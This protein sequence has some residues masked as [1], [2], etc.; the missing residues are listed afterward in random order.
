MLISWYG[1]NFIAELNLPLNEKTNQRLVEEKETELIESMNPDW[2][3]LY[4]ELD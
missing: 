2:K 4:D 1:L 3:D